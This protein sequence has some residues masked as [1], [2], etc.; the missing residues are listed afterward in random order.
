MRNAEKIVNR[1]LEG[2]EKIARNE[3]KKIVLGDRA[4]CAAICH[5][6]KRP[7]KK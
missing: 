2:V 5:Q 4:E 7:K 1:V 6:P 3:V